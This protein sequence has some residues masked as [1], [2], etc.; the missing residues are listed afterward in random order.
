MSEF[1]AAEL[2]E[3]IREFYEIYF[4]SKEKILKRYAG[5]KVTTLVWLDGRYK[6]IPR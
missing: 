2:N 4:G 5:F 3:V 6:A 1:N